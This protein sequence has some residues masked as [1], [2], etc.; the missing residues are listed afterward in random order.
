MNL[1][2]RTVSFKRREGEGSK[3]SVR[4]M[5]TCALS[6]FRPLLDRRDRGAHEAE[7]EI[8]LSLPVTLSLSLCLC[9]SLSRTCRPRLVN[10]G[11]AR[12]H[13]RP[14]STCLPLCLSP[15]LS[16]SVYLSVCPSV[17]P[18]L[19]LYR[20]LPLSIS[21]SPRLSL[22]LSLS[23]RLSHGHL[24]SFFFPTFSCSHETPSA[25]HKTECSPSAFQV[26]QVSSHHTRVPGS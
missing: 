9:V 19:S 17:S 18:R 25:L 7:L 26:L 23:L 14:T 24:A 21:V 12:S 10:L 8:C 13:V 4:D 16:V 6:P 2:C 22:F 5:C 3:R 15:S 20:S 1:C 11:S